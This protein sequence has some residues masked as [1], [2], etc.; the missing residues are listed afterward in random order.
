MSAIVAAHLSCRLMFFEPC[1]H[2]VVADGVVDVVLNG[3]VLLN[4]LANNSDDASGGCVLMGLD[5]HLSLL[6]MTL[7]NCS[8]PRN[9]GRGGAVAVGKRSSLVVKNSFIM[10]G[11]AGLQGGG[12]HSEEESRLDLTGVSFLDSSSGVCANPQVTCSQDA[13]WLDSQYNQYDCVFFAAN[14]Q[15]CGIGGSDVAC[16]ACD[17]GQQTRSCEPAGAGGGYYAASRVTVTMKEVEFQR[18][19]EQHCHLYIK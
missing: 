12:L 16:C 11:Y 4:G 5:S 13:T 10:N 2:F 6:N 3:L 14:M 8:A 18:H 15:Y 1:R 19:C 17:G 9:G 7:R